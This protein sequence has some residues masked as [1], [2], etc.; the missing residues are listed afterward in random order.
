MGAV[1]RRTLIALALLAFAAVAAALG[2]ASWWRGRDGAAGTGR[3]AA[4]EPNVGQQFGVN[5]DLLAM[6]PEGRDA[7]LD[8]AVGAGITWVRQHVLW[9]DVEP[10]KGAY[11]WE[12][13][14]ALVAAA[15]ERGLNVIV[16][17]GG[18][19]PWARPAGQEQ[20]LW[21]PPATYADFGDFCA[22][23]AARYGDRIDYY[24]IWDEPN[25]YPHWG[26]RYVDA[27]EYTR[28]LREAATRI[29]DED[30]RARI[31]LAGLAPNLEDGPLN[32]NEAEFLR[33]VYRSGGAA[34]FDIVAAKPYGFEYGAGE[35]AD[36]RLG[37][38]R[39]EELR[40]LMME[41]GDEGKPLWAVEF[42]WSALPEGWQ[43]QQSPWPTADASVQAAR[44][45]DAVRLARQQWPWMGP[46]LW[47]QLTPAASADD[48][49]TGFA[50]LDANLQPTALGAALLPAV[51][52]LPV[53]RVGYDTPD[54]AAATYSGDWRVTATGAD[55]SASGDS[56]EI[57]FA[58]TAV[59]LLL[60]PGPYW[61]VW[62]VTVDG[63]PAPSLPQAD[64]RAY[65]VLYDPLGAERQVPVARGL[66]PGEHILRLEVDGGWQQWPLA[67]W[68][69]WQEEPAAPPWALPLL[70][71]GLVAGLAG[72]AL[73]PGT[74][75]TARWLLR[76][77]DGVAG[78][79]PAWL[80]GLAVA[81]LALAFWFADGMAANA[82]LG[83]ALALAMLA[84][85]AWG[86]ALVAASLPF[87]LLPKHLP[88][89]SPSLTELTSWLLLLVVVARRAI[90][91][92]SGVA[93][94]RLRVRLHG[95]DVAVAGLL[96]VSL[97]S[98]AVAANYGV[99][100]TEFRRVILSA[101]V[102]YVA[103]RLLPRPGLAGC[104]ALGFIAG[105]TLASLWGI[106]QL[107]TGSGLIEAGGVGRV[108]AAYGSP[109]NLA[110]YLERVIPLAGALALYG[111]GRR[112][113]LLSLVALAVM[114]ACGA[115]TRSRGLILLALPVSALYLVWRG[116]WLRGRRWLL[117]PAA[118]V[119]VAA[120]ALA[121]GRV[122]SLL[123]GNDEASGMRLQVWQSALN[124]VRDH[125]LLGVGLDNFL[126]EY[127]TH[128]ILPSAW[129][130]P[131]LSHPHNL[132]LDAWTRLGIGGVVVIL[133][134]F[135]GGWLA[136]RRAG[137]AGTVERAVFLG[138]EA[139][140]VGAVAHGLV[141]N[142]F[143]LVD[144]SHALLG[145]LAL[146][147]VAE[148]GRLLDLT[149]H[150]RTEAGTL[151]VS[152]EWGGERESVSDGRRRLH[153]VAPL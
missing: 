101:V 44:G 108:R 58:G 128:Y 148:P 99:A 79:V 49:R 78:R 110:L 50:L 25:I 100:A 127:R 6:A 105:A 106:A 53:A 91:A 12:A 2:A 152:L 1:R 45:A 14:D 61:A 96:A 109:N 32:L 92:P 48:P 93:G 42:G 63:L 82:V 57:R 80:S 88:G 73:L 30:E 21:T 111:I 67:G 119:L 8:A 70:A 10:A 81:A 140:I 59:D 125:P 94:M 149:L 114:L 66:A 86:A 120:L 107:V 117:L 141:D 47:A 138:I 68:V 122:G 137:A 134:L 24:E 41:A 84:W 113:R 18:T 102:F 29:R 104:L 123:S 36:G 69:S 116:G 4:V 20:Q 139:A 3:P 124:M 16:V 5:V 76:G 64:G 13:S 71:L 95:L 97:L 60:R 39:A 40:A 126:Y 131:N 28:L 146:V 55:P 143:F 89:F 26:D 7:A 87:F 52:D 136:A 121:T 19:P 90:G 56:V 43:G 85:P 11:V 62:Y 72:L 23:F 74:F 75:A 147:V 17:L 98:L 31:L 150:A 15:A 65:V 77:L 132:V 118:V 115:L 34:F 135:V 22:A 27:A 145:M 142:S 9:S 151:A 153:R 37:F 130:E 133:W 51:R 54:S 33:Q 129:H 38:R 144:L 83:A 35:A 112:Q 103:V 46:L